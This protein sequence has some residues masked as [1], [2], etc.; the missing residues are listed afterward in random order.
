MDRVSVPLDSRFLELFAKRSSV[1]RKLTVVHFIVWES[2]ADEIY[3]TLMTRIPEPARYNSVE[4]AKMSQKKNTG[5][6]D[7][8]AVPDDLLP[9][10]LGTSF[11]LRDPHIRAVRETK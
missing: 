2:D 9:E 5:D 8:L 4:K 10:L 6:D 3:E 1:G 7:P 11:V